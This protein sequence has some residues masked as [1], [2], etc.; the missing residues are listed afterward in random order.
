MAYFKQDFYNTP[1]AVPKSSLFANQNS[2]NTQAEYYGRLTYSLN[3]NLQLAGVYHY[4][5]SNFLNS[6]YNNHIGSLGL[7]YNGTHI[8]LQGDVNTG[9]MIGGRLNQYSAS[10]TFY[11][12]GNLNIYTF[13]R[14]SY[15]DQNGNGT[16]IFAQS[17]GYKL[18]NTLWA[19]TAATFGNLNNYIDVDGLYIYNAIDPTKLKLGQTFFYRLGKHAQLQL[20][21]TYE[22]KEDNIH[23]LTY[24]QHALTTGLLWKF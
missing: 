17:V 1:V 3:A 2:A 21:Y 7:R 23:S 5:K 20:N 9:T 14:G 13:S 18:T 10:L 12:A 19:E 24:N 16:G 8:A 6:S 22:Q 11:P 15:L 4:L